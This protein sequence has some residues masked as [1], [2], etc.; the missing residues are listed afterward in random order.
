MKRKV[1]QE[2]ELKL[3]GSQ[4]A[5][6][7]AWASPAL[8]AGRI[9]SWAPERLIS[10]YYDT[11]DRA[12]KAAGLTL[13]VR[14]KGQGAFVQTVKS[15]AGPQTAALVRTEDEAAIDSP[16][17]HLDAVR[18]PTFRRIVKRALK[19]GLKPL[20]T[21]YVDRKTIEVAGEGGARI[22][23]SLDVGEARNPDTG[24]IAPIGEI[25]LE[26]MEGR[27]AALYA[28]ARILA[29]E[30]AL[31]LSLASKAA[32]GFRLAD[33][34]VP[35]HAKAARLTLAPKCDAEAALAEILQ[36]STAHLF[37]NIDAVVI[38]GA[39]EGAHQM[40]VALRRLRAALVLFKKRIDP[41]IASGLV[42][43][44]KYYANAL[45]AAR[46]LDVF[47][48]ETLA[49]LKDL[50][51]DEACLRLIASRAEA[52]RQ[53]AWSDARRA[54]DTQAFT[55]FLLDLSAATDEA[56]IAAKTTGARRS[57]KRFAR[58]AIARRWRKAFETGADFVHLS[59]H[60]RHP[61]RIELKKLR[62]AA[63][64][65]ASLYPE[66]TVKP[67][68][69]RLS[70]LQDDFGAMNDALVAADIADRLAAPHFEDT[71]ETRAG[72]AR[73]AGLITGWRKAVMDA[74]WADAQNRWAE[75][76]A[77]PQFWEKAGRGD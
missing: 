15:T 40:R 18:E 46:D 45:G 77:A 13:R 10:T 33:K 9:S 39:P 73:A 51:P 60:D 5:L 12:L 48:A 7:A 47:A 34:T 61:L 20:F 3:T 63:V 69:K 65:F 28:L 1:V 50:M 64:F 19:Q 56:I 23:A 37:G 43:Q 24:D 21:V 57:A 26:L 75:L 36:N 54:L 41:R 14:D 27:P 6:K 30:G 35:G 71:A 42:L 2:V 38:A 72:L 44:A 53:A 11:E 68:L 55:S 62:Y 25:E 16:A 17:P 66:E 67:Y 8:K 58:K 32:R 49:P 76:C 70:R 74:A 22:E 59:P 4:G 52:A 31:R 29:A